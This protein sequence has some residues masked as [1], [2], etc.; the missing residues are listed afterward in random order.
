[1]VTPPWNS[2]RL[3]SFYTLQPG[4]KHRLI[5]YTSIESGEPSDYV[6]TITEGYEGDS[7][8]RPSLSVENPN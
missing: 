6:V 3:P 8:D 1:M 5:F 2:D 4:R 7:E